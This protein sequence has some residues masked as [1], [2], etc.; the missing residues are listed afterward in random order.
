MK[1][2]IIY[3]ILI[4]CNKQN[5]PVSNLHSPNCGHKNKK[6]PK[7]LRPGNKFVKSTTYSLLM[8]FRLFKIINFI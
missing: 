4:I 8:Y 1:Y 7:K 5:E 3:D 2:M 6:L